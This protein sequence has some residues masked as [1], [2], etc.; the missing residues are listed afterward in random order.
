MEY[1]LKNAVLVNEGRCVKGE[2]WIKDGKI[3]GIRR[4]EEEGEGLFSDGS[5]RAVGDSLADA[6]LSGRKV[7][8]GEAFPEGGTRPLQTG[9]Y[10]LQDGFAMGKEYESAG[11]QVMDLKGACVL[12]GIIDDQVHF[13]QPGLTHK[14]DIASESLA[15]LKGGVTSFMDMPNTKPQTLTQ[16]LLAQKYRM[17]AEDS[18]VNYSFYMGCSE[19][20]LNEVLK[21][22]PRDVCGIKLFLGSSTGNMLV[23]DP[24]YLEALFANAPTIV[25]AHCE[26]E[27][28]IRQNTADFKARY[29]DAAPFSIH[30]L[31]RSAE[32]CY[33]SSSKAA[34]LARKHGA[35]LHILHLSTAKELELLGDDGIS[36]EI[37]VHYL[38]FSDQDYGKYGWRM[39]CNPAIKTAEDRE[40]LRRA[41]KSG[42]LVVATD[43]APHTYEEKQKPYFECP[44]G[45]PWVGHSLPMMLELVHQGIF[46]L[47]EV[48]EAMCHR[49]ARLFQIAG[50]GFLRPGYAADLAIVD[51]EQAWQVDKQNIDY[52]CGWSALEGQVLHGKVLSTFVNGNLVYD[53]GEVLMPGYRGERLLFER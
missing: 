15:A 8:P 52:K 12:P 30:P 53:R 34:A 45:S 9:W 4:V 23:E 22:D 39:K 10:S 24:A 27:S 16:D 50:R 49:P 11:C 48:V 47:T 13:R 29:G 38:W 26:E 41:V 5:R 25:A 6:E 18:H 17:G 51:P 46:S 40:A 36:G 43:H 3:E 14:G 44:S 33:Q 1:L 32:A 20:N 42:K 7:L 37:C 28:I 31:V 2:M 21:T 19:D 35:K